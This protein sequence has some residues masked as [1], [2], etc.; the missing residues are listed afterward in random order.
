M[1][2]GLSAAFVTGRS[3]SVQP[4]FGEEPASEFVT[5]NSS[6]DACE[7]VTA[8]ITLAFCD[9][10]ISPDFVSAAVGAWRTRMS[11]STTRS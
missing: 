11:R 9:E 6:F 7:S 3:S 4:P 1:F 5:M 2:S 8:N 10:A